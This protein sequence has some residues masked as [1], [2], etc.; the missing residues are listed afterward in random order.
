MEGSAKPPPAGWYVDPDDAALQRFW[1]GSRWTNS[2]MPLTDAV[3]LEGTELEPAPATRY[4]SDL[5]PTPDAEAAADTGLPP[6]AWYVDPENPE[7]MRYWDGANW[8]ENR[9]DYV[10][11]PPKK[12]AS[13]GMVAAGYITA[14][15]FPLIGVVIGV[16][17]MGRDNRHG[18]WILAI[19]ALLMLGFLL[20]GNL[21]DLDDQNR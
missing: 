16:M 19:S 8:T 2:R 12:P 17:L 1:D 7:G 20:L 5:Q 13:E 3:P 4:A 9:T 14:F 10:A 21:G 18:R 11:A 15:L 6:A